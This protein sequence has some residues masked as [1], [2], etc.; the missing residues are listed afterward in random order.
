M[1]V[2]VNVDVDGVV[3]DFND[4]ITQFA[5]SAWKMCLPPTE[6][7][8]IWK[9][10]GVT[11]EAFDE[12]MFHGI[13]ENFVFRCGR[14]IEDAR[15]GL[16]GLV[17]SG[18]RVRL[19]TAKVFEDPMIQLQAQMNTLRWLHDFEMPFHEIAFTS[20]KRGYIADFVI[21]DKPSLSWAQPAAT[22]IL[23]GQPWNELHK[24]PVAVS[25]MPAA[26]VRASG[27]RDVVSTILAEMDIRK[28]VEKLLD[29]RE[30]VGI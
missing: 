15:W 5:E 8:Q 12:V 7:W 17:Y 2:T 21:D 10:W 29:G 22:N 30:R 18:F 11:A 16:R 24:L 4:A 20:N 26:F 6:H 28:S 14:D 3:Y 19:V 23:F 25:D 27:W 13:R 1:K 9:S